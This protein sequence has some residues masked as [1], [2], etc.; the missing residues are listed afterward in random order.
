[1]ST[2]Y[3][4]AERNVEN[5]IDWSKVGGAFSTMLKTEA[6]LR[7][8]KKADIEKATEQTLQTLADAP[9]GLDRGVNENILNYASQ[10]QNYLL[11]MNR[12]LKSGQL[13]PKDY[14]IYTQNLKSDT[15]KMLSGL[16]LGKLLSK[17][18]ILGL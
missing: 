10:G 1:M 7:E 5:Q 2:Y 8:K 4:Y 3:K 12:L 6:E 11:M 18:F 16:R 14:S 13:D 9:T 15:Q 17:K